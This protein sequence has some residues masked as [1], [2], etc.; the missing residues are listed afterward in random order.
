MHEPAQ[1][2]QLKEL[3]CGDIGQYR[4]KTRSSSNHK[5]R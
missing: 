1:V 3:V 5:S 4:L 2:W